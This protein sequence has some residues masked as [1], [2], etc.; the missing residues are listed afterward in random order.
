M[1]VN[2]GND[3]WAVHT[4]FGGV[5]IVKGEKEAE[6]VEASVIR[7][8]LWALCLAPIFAIGTVLVLSVILK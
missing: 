2:L 1:K 8:N 7:G 5:A 4:V 3:Q 6:Q